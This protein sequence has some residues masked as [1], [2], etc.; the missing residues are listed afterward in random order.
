MYYA[1]HDVT[2][3]PIEVSGSDDS[4]HDVNIAQLL[5]LN[6]ELPIKDDPLEQQLEVLQYTAEMNDAVV[7][8]K[9]VWAQPAIGDLSLSLAGGLTCLAFDIIERLCNK[10]QAA[11]LTQR[12]MLEVFFK[13]NS[14][15]DMPETAQNASSGG[16]ACNFAG[17]T[18]RAML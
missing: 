3:D 2:D 7:A 15:S 12:R 17:Q 14:T 10:K 6:H 16:M 11:G 8:S 5:V 4:P 1:L 9:R 18:C 13:R